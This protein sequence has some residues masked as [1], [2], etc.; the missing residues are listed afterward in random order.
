[1][2][3]TIYLYPSVTDDIRENLFQ[4][5]PYR[6]TYTGRDGTDNDLTYEEAEVT[7][8]VNC[9]K[10][11]GVWNAD[12]FNLCVRRTVALKGYKKLFGPDGLACRNAKLGMGFVWTSADSKQRGAIPIIAFGISEEEQ[13]EKSDHS[14]VQGEIDAEFAPARLRGD[15]EFDVMLY[16]AQAGTP[17]SDEMHLANQEGF[18]L[19]TLDSFVL[20]LDGTGSLFPVFEVFEHDKPLWSVRCDWIDPTVDSFS[21][22]VSININKAHSNYKFID[23]TQKTYCSQLL[24]E[25]MSAALCCIME[26]IRSEKYLDQMLGTDEM[27][28]GSVGEA[29]RYFANTLNWDF[30]TPDRLSLS[31]RKFFDGRLTD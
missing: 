4:A 14:F 22:S 10:T 29:V 26:K 23:R 12:N 6:F 24:V 16:I 21:E 11:D 3:T 28:P 15:I 7:S 25:V 8:S 13:K 9:L 1:M 20:R 19:G 27:E 2:S 17:A 18:I 31:I 30:S 5:K